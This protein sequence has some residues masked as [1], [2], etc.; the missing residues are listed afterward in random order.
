MAAQ[1]R[2]GKIDH[3][4]EISVRRPPGFRLPLHGF[5]RRRAGVLTNRV[6]RR[7]AVGSVN[8]IARCERDSRSPSD[9]DRG[10]TTAQWVET[11]CLLTERF[12]AARPFMGAA[13]LRFPLSN[14]HATIY[15]S[16]RPDDCFRVEVLDVGVGGVGLR[17]EIDL[18]VRTAITLRFADDGPRTEP[19]N[20]IVLWVRPF[21]G[22]TFH[23]GTRLARPAS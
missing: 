15:R 12:G 6:P 13:H 10:V 7:A 8:Q 20:L 4:N 23:I 19:W 9:G 17:S 5:A 14:C 2:T 3:G 22:G 16:D 21:E 11:A 1:P 18:P